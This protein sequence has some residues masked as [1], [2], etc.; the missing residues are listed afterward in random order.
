[1]ADTSAMGDGNRQW[2]M[3]IGNGRWKSAMGDG[4]R[5]WAMEI[6]NGQWKS[7]MNE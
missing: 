2:A 1:M 6:G 7:P 5:Q 3:E 4:N